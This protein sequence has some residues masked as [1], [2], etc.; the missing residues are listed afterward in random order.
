MWIL[1]YCKNDCNSRFVFR[2]CV[3]LSS[4]YRKVPFLTATHCQFR[5]VGQD[6]KQQY[7]YMWYPLFQAQW[8]RC[9]QQNRQTYNYLVMEIIY[10]A[11]FWNERIWLTSFRFCWEAPLWILPLINKGI[12]RREEEYSLKPSICNVSFYFEDKCVITCLYIT[13]HWYAAAFHQRLYMVYISLSWSDIPEHVVPIRISLIVCCY[14]QEATDSRVPIGWAE[15]EAPLWILPLIN[16]G[17]SRREEEYS[18]K[19][20]ICNVSFYFE[21]KCVITCLY[22]PTRS[23]F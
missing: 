15:W 16:K 20:S 10:I 7:M 12:S 8:D 11:A 19:P 14:E 13:F 2:N 9:D 6:M 22:I 4:F 18:L 3:S 17:I 1:Q 23:I 21:D 5:G